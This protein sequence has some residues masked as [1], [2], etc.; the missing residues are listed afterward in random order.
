VRQANADPKAG[1]QH[2][3]VANCQCSRHQGLRTVQPHYF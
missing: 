1:R 3:T 2:A